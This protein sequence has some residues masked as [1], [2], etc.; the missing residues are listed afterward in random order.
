[1]I[2]T[3]FSLAVVETSNQSEEVYMNKVMR[4]AFTWLF[5]ALHKSSEL[6]NPQS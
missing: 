4:L 3:L 6:H 1:M 2:I 5:L